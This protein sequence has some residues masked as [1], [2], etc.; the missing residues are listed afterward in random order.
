MILFAAAFIIGQA[1]QDSGKWGELIDP[2]CFTTVMSYTSSWSP[3][4]KNS[5]LI[6]A[7]DTFLANRLLWFTISVIVLS[8]AYYRFR[9]RTNENL[10]KEKTDK[11][12]QPG[13]KLFNTLNPVLSISTPEITGNFNLESQLK[14]LLIITWKAFL[15]IAKNKA[16]LPLL[17]LLALIIWAVLPANLEARNVP[18]LHRTD[19]ILNYLAAPLIQPESFWII[20]ALLTIYYAGELIWRDREAGLN[21]LANTTPVREWQLFLGRFLALSIILMIW[22]ALLTTAGILTQ[23]GTLQTRVEF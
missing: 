10:Q 1:L 18:L 22:M 3:L 23:T 5:R 16:G 17:I 6:L 8:I 7:G 9:F 20:V 19:V 2:M 13:T 21:E 12:P 14:Q 4:E 11:Y 15:Q